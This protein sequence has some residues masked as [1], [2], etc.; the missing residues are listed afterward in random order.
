MKKFFQRKKIQDNL[1]LY[2]T[3]ILYQKVDITENIC[4]SFKL[5]NKFFKICFKKF[6][7]MNVYIIYDIDNVIFDLDLVL[8]YLHL[9][10]FKYIYILKSDDLSIFLFKFKNNFFY[11]YLLSIILHYCYFWLL[12]GSE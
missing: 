5:R 4:K 10:S 7:Y 1:V 9:N 12:I 6:I 8:G 3:L 2:N 11:K